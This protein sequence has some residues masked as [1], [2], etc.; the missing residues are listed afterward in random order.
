MRTVWRGAPHA[1]E[2]PYVFDTVR[3]HYGRRTSRADE[4][5]ARLMHAYWVAFAKT[6]RPDPAG[7]PAWPEYHTA[8]DRLLN[9]TG[10]GPAIERDPW[11]RR[12]DLAEAAV[13]SR[14]RH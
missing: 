3:A 8:T 1:T 9:F 10:H 4:S 12:L 6:G 7:E 2:I 14:T 11:R 13:H 5:M